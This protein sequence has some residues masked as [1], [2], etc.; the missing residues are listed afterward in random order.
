MRTDS[1]PKKTK[2]GPKKEVIVHNHKT[3]MTGI[4]DAAEIKSGNIPE[5]LADGNSI[6]TGVSDEE[7]RQLIAK[8]AYYRAE[9][10]SF[11]PGHELEDWL[12]AEAEIEMKLTDF[13]TDNLS[14]NSQEPS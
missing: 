14:K 11:E 1:K 2:H 4:A 8:A 9:Q 7:R 12:T 10:R 6:L 5:I 3:G 13:V